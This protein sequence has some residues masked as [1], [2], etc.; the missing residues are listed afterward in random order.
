MI[1]KKDRKNP[2]KEIILFLKTTSSKNSLQ[3]LIKISKKNQLKNNEISLR[4]IRLRKLN[5]K[6]LQQKKLSLLNK[7]LTKIKYSPI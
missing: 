2:E 1:K 3:T 6:W 5:N 4:K 7:V